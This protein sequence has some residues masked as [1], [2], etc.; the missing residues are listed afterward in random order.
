MEQQEQSEEIQNPSGNTTDNEL[1]VLDDLLK[2]LTTN[3]PAYLENIVSKI[4]I[5]VQQHELNTSHLSFLYSAANYQE[6][7][8]SFILKHNIDDLIWELRNGTQKLPV[9]SHIKVLE[10]LLHFIN[11]IYLFYLYFFSSRETSRGKV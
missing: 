5:I 4:N 1:A 3:P 8:K 9:Q 2:K 10:L 7:L 6:A 11:K